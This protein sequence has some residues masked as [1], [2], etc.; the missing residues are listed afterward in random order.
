MDLHQ[1]LPFY[2][3]DDTQILD[4]I[5]DSEIGE[6]PTIN[7]MN[8]V[9]ELDTMCFFNFTPNEDRHLSDS[10][11][12]YFMQN[13][14]G[15]SNSDCDYYFIDNTLSNALLSSQSVLSVI[16]FNINSIPLHFDT[17]IDQ[18]ISPIQ[19]VFDIF[20]FLRNKTFKLY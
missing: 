6:Q 2:N 18:C 7:L 13:S 1:Y 12:D 17:Y 16:N 20:V 9:S 5:R 15:Y 3:V 4:I 19:H 14:L 10:D 11:P 8:T